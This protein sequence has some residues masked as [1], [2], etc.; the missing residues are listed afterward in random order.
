MILIFSNHRLLCYRLIVMLV[1][2]D[3]FQRLRRQLPMA[4]EV[5]GM[6]T[7]ETTG[8]TELQE[9]CNRI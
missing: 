1:K 3:C 4:W 5:E 6:T 2:I 7:T 8:V 9:N